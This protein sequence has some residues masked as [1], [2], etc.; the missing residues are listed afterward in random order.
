MKKLLKRIFCLSVLLLLLLPACAQTVFTHPWQGKRVAY[1]GDSLTDPTAPAG[2]E[3]YWN[4]LREQLGITPYVYAVNGREWNDI[5]RQ[6][7]QLEKEH[8]RDFDAI[9]IFM[10]TND[11]NAGIPVGTWYTESIEEVEAATGEQRSMK[12]RKRRVPVMDGSTLCGRINI[13]MNKI[14]TMFPGKQVVLLTPIHRA[15]AMFGDTNV[16]PSE[17][18]QNSCGEWFSDYVEAVRQAGSV[19]SVPVI[20]LYAVSGIYPLLES[21]SQYLN[22]AQ[23][24]R[25]HLNPKGHSRLGATLVY[26]LLTLPCTF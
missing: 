14:K 25:L 10:G 4:V 16:Q 3:K 1:F 21:N 26:Q 22:N 24:D 9:M 18:Y 11:Y 23:T 8:G 5:P 12:T 7:E 19:W 2:N 6:A 15:Y 17:E 13:A 20:D